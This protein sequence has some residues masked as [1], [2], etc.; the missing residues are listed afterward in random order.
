MCLL[1]QIWPTQLV[2]PFWLFNIV[3]TRPSSTQR[4]KVMDIFCQCFCRK[5]LT[6]ITLL[7]QTFWFHL[8]KVP[9]LPSHFN[10]MAFEQTSWGHS[11]MIPDKLQQKS[12][13]L[14]IIQ[15]YLEPIVCTARNLSVSVTMFQHWHRD[16][17]TPSYSFSFTVWVGKDKTF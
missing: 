7:K 16:E 10:L 1:C 11:V 3:F 14:D 6:M 4:S 8:K 13:E 15:P 9:R 5:T 2:Y 12:S 17:T